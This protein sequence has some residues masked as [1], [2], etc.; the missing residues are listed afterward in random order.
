[1][2]AGWMMDGQQ[3]LRHGISSHGLWPGEL[4]KTMVTKVSQDI[5]STILIYV[6]KVTPTIVAKVKHTQILLVDDF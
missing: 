3:T 6:A 4:K 2:P 5:M 1:M